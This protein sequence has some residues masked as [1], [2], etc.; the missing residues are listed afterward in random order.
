MIVRQKC[1]IV[2]IKNVQ[3]VWATFYSSADTGASTVITIDSVLDSL[4]WI[5]FSLSEETLEF[6]VE[7][8]SV[9]DTAALIGK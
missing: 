1:T 8:Q 2:K 6:K 3:G 5:Y 7:L 4:L 9:S